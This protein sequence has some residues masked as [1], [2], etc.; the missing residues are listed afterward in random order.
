M[1][2]SLN[3]KSVVW[4]LMAALIRGPEKRLGLIDDDGGGVKP[5]MISRQTAR[6]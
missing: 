1:I 4:L 6:P 3:G 5:L 2:Y